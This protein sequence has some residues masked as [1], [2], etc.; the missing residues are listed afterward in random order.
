LPINLSEY[1]F[2]GAL[3]EAKGMEEIRRRF[4]GQ[5]IV[6][7]GASKNGMAAGIP[8]PFYSLSFLAVTL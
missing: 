2:V 8:L 4:A 7:V 6:L 3:T 1:L 5:E